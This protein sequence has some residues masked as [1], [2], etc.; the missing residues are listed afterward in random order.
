MEGLFIFSR[1]RLSRAKD[2]RLLSARGVLCLLLL[3]LGVAAQTSRLVVTE[4]VQPSFALSGFRIVDLA[5]APGK[6]ILLVGR[7]G[8]VRTF[9]PGGD[10]GGLVGSL[11]L[12][13]P[14]ST[15]LGL[16][17]Y[18]GTGKPPWLVAAGRRRTF[19][20][21]VGANGAYAKDAVVLAN[22]AKGRRQPKPRI[23]IRVGE[24]RFARILRDLN[25]DGRDDLT[26]P[27][28]RSVDVWVNDGAKA[29]AAS[30]PPRFRRVA[31]L[32]V[33][34]RRRLGTDFERLSDELE[35]TFVVPELRVADVNGDGRLDLLVES[36]RKRAF[37]LQKADGTIPEVPDE[38]LNLRIFNDTTP[39]ASVR[40]GRTL[41]GGNRQTLQSRDLDGDGIPDYVIAHRRKVWVFHGGRAGPQFKRTTQILRSAD[42]V[43]TLALL[44]LQPDGRPDLVV[45]KVQVPSVAGVIMGALGDLEVEV[46]AIGY[47]SKN[48]KG[49]ETSPRWKSELTFKLP[50][51]VSIL[52]DPYAIIRRFE[53]AGNR[54]DG[55]VEGDL[56]GDGKVDILVIER[57]K[58]SARLWLGSKN[59]PVA[60]DDPDALLRNVLF[61]DPNRNWDLD[62]LVDLVARV[63]DREIGRRTGGRPADV[64]FDLRSLD[65]HRMLEA[66][67]GDTDG[68]GR[69]ELVISYLRVSDETR[70]VVDIL[71]LQ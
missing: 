51:I 42:D 57:Q 25:G 12:P 16:S 62:R 66:Q 23:Q 33:S 6:E 7:Q 71:R 47:A 49:F 67:T 38:T 61:E 20:Y 13:E 69:D 35:S 17:A 43:T 39:K 58:A 37:H 11:V 9:V 29:G 28:G 44:D 54:F 56:D 41:A 5:K 21:R 52:R 64:T 19:A 59:P 10:G 3:G 31:A 36:G 60:A 22:V 30:A 26:L 8:E 14:S 18:G 46:S 68:D 48:G 53:E 1:S 34:V 24:P 15:L 70:P 45:I 2:R 63:A 32:P 40:P 4:S 55:A 27:V 65:D 50:S